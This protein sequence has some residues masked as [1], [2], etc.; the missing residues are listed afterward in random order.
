MSLFGT[1]LLITGNE[2]LLVQRAMMQRKTQA[3]GQQPAAD[4]NQIQAG[5][6]HDAILSE[7]IGGSL[8]ASH[9]VAVIEDLGS[10]PAEVADQLVA[11]A[12]NPP[13]ELCLILLHDG[14][15]KGRGI[16]NQL[17]KAKVPTEAVKAPP[18]WK[19]GDFVAAE[20]KAC[21]VRFAAGATDELLAAVGSDLR[22]LASAVSQ[23]A[24]DASSTTV[25]ADLVKRYFAGRAEVTSFAV[26]DAV[27]AG[28]AT[29][30]LERLR[31]A[32]HIGTAHVLITSSLA[33]S[34]RALGKYLDAQTSRVRGDDL[35]RLIG[36]TPFQLKTL[37]PAARGWT[38]G[39]VAEAIELIAAADADVK[40]A[41]GDAEYAL[42]KL[43]LGVLAQ[44]RR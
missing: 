7:V 3:L 40:G 14:G 1:A 30:A 31:W 19:L 24:A 21:G 33:R 42:E 8:F 26:A 4:V 25:D 39:G 38:P 9:I 15:N 18:P 16:I 11:A 10:C 6:L 13:E 20:A 23:L 29:L 36:V 17:K 2:P 32:L 27:L 44:R 12:A 35:A 41:A 37:V 43:V 28:H 34:F 22:A 5:Q